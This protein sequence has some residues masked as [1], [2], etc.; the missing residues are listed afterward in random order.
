[1]KITAVAFFLFAASLA[2]AGAPE[3]KAV[4]A[5]KCQACHGANGEGKASI[6]KMFNVTMHPLGSKEIQSMSDADIKKVVTEG[7]GKMK[8]VTGLDDKQVADVVAFVR[9]LKE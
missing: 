5:A 2:Y 9:T 7:H 8:P 3:G 6:A 4:F 1:M